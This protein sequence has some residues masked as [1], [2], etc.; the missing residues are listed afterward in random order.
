MI[1]KKLSV[2]DFIMNAQYVCYEWRNICKDPL[3]WHTI[4]MSNTSIY[5]NR[6]PHCRNSS[7]MTIMFDSWLKKM[8]K[9][10][11]DLSAGHLIYI[12]I[13]DFGDKD[14]LEY[15]INSSSQIRSLR[16]NNCCIYDK[17]R[18]NVNELAKKLPQLYN[19]SICFCHAFSKD[20]LEAIGIC[21]PRLTKL[22]LCKHYK[23]FDK[24]NKIYNDEDGG[25]DGH[26]EDAFVIA[27]TM[28]QLLRLRLCQN[29]IT[30]IGLVAILD[31][32]P[33]LE[34]LRVIKCDYL[35]LKGSLLERCVRQIKYFQ[36]DTEE[37][38]ND[39]HWTQI[40]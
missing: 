12:D 36:I 10:M 3:T 24:E 22:N 32:C 11:I 4:V 17:K 39:D 38:K 5:I 27:K 13:C 7:P 23:C 9:C 20:F 29:K 34:F 26:D 14:L 16:F 2:Y 40:L 31:G 25:D 6:H 37:V 18:L 21:C 30:N 1:L 33:R 19:L 8:C 15:I 28:P 35:N